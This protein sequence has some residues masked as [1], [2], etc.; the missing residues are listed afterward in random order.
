MGHIP[1]DTL[2]IPVLHT[3]AEAMSA[4][5]ILAAAFLPGAIARDRDRILPYAEIDQ[6]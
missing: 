1:S 4:A 6:Y 2:P 5:R 3:D